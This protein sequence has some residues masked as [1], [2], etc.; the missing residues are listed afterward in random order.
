MELKNLVKTK[1]ELTNDKTIRIATVTGLARAIKR[2]QNRSYA[3]QRQYGKTQSI[4]YLLTL[5]FILQ[6]MALELLRY[7]NYID[8]I[9]QINV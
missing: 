6:K 2:E 4:F 5:Y 7:H 9:F 1:K 3:Y 8:A